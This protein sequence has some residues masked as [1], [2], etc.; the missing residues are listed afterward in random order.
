[1]GANFSA[2]RTQSGGIPASTT[3]DVCL[4]FTC[5]KNGAG[6]PNTCC[7]LDTIKAIARGFS[8]FRP[9]PNVGIQ[10]FGM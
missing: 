8:V 5:A 3:D 9:L 10:H 7:K 4:M 6:F 2:R 1:M